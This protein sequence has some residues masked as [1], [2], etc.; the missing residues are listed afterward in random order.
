MS[1]L[2]IGKDNDAVFLHF[3]RGDS[4]VGNFN[5]QQEVTVMFKMRTKDIS[6]SRLWAL[7][8]RS[9]LE[10]HQIE[11]LLVNIRVKENLIDV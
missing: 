4:A 8:S 9:G 5:F 1:S 2:S 7:F 3:F 10:N 11:I 6:Y